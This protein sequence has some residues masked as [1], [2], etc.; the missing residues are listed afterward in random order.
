[1]TKSYKEGLGN[2]VVRVKKLQE[3]H[4]C[5]KFDMGLSQKRCVSYIFNMKTF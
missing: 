3:F 1:M 2:S 4:F 5:T